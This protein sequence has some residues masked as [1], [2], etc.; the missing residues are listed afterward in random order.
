MKS[1]GAWARSVNIR[2]RPSLLNDHFFTD[3]A[4]LSYIDQ[5]ARPPSREKYT[6]SSPA[7][8][9]IGAGRPASGVSMIRELSL[10]PFAALENILCFN[11]LTDLPAL[12]LCVT[13]ISLAPPRYT[14]IRRRSSGAAVVQFTRLH[15][16]CQ[17]VCG[18]GGGRMRK[19]HFAVLGQVRNTAFSRIASRSPRC[20]TN[21]HGEPAIVPSELSRGLLRPLLQRTVVG[22]RQPGQSPEAKARVGFL[23]CRQCSEKRSELNGKKSR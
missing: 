10:R 8:L 5:L 7:D 11:G 12:H 21:S 13:A 2:P 17:P 22:G 23:A 15:A 9:T 19:H 4:I 20:I 14:E 6:H 18:L 1:C 3:S 16:N